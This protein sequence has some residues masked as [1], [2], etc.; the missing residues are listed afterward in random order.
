MAAATLTALPP[1]APPDAGPGLAHEALVIGASAGGV[2]AVGQLLAALPRACPLKI[3]VVIH[4]PAERPSLLA[5]LFAARCALPVIE[6]C[7][8][9]PIRCGEVL[10]APPDY[11]LL[12]EAGSTVA[13]SM[14]EPV[15]YSRPAI[16]P[17]FESA[18]LVWGR[19]LL[20]ILLTGGSADGSQGLAAVRRCGGTAWVQ[21]PLTAAVPTM[22][23]AGLAAAGADA[24]L[25]LTE[26]ARRLAAYA[27]EAAH[28]EG[29][30]RP[31]M[32]GAPPAKKG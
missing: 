28:H 4:V 10:I 22:P 15:L 26:M 19:R 8:K 16:D 1:S 3:L 21:D 5:G 25:D 31:P 6:A 9:A 20:A 30:V 12:V 24:V 32:P 27:G 18:A 17:L 7:D 23:A 29:G 2:D 14:D 11:H 13:L